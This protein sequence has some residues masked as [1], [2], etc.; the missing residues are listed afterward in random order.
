[1][2]TVNVWSQTQA[3]RSILRDPGLGNF[4]VIT[5][6]RRWGKDAKGVFVDLWKLGYDR[7]MKNGRTPDKRNLLRV[8]THDMVLYDVAWG[9]KVAK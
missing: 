7:S 8:G 9:C 6:S 5:E 4:T 3:Q 1:M 2:S